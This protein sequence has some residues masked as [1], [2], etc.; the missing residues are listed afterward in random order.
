MP[1]R[2]LKQ[3]RMTLGAMLSIALMG[4]ALN[5]NADVPTP[6][7]PKAVKGEQC[8][9]ETAFM[10]RNHMDLLDHQRDG[11]LRQGIRTKKHS[12]N[13]CLSCHVVKD[14]NNQ[15]VT[16]QSEKHFCRSCHEYAAVKID[17]FGCHK[18]TPDQSASSL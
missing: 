13:G 3:L 9:E 8:V 10:R 2:F 4:F 17:C 7:I 12:L 16:F 6:Q 5:L 11:T 1:M 18:S 15:A 14:S